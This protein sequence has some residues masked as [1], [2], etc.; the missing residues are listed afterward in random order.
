M[1]AI[2]LMPL[3][4]FLATRVPGA[5]ASISWVAVY[6]IPLLLVGSLAQL[7]I[8]DTL[9]IQ[10]LSIATVY[11]VYEVGYLQND[12]LT[13]RGE[14]SPTLRLSPDEMDNV[15]RRFTVIALVRAVIVILLLALLYQMDPPGMQGLLVSLAIL[16]PT[17]VIYNL[18]RGAIN[19]PLHFLLVSLRFC[20]PVLVLIPYPDATLLLY[21]ILLFPLIN[22]LER[23]AE[24]RYGLRWA[25][26]NPLA[27]QSSGRWQYYLGLGALWSVT[28][29][30]LDVNVMTLVPIAYLFAYRL[31]S[32][33]ALSR[34]VRSGRGGEADQ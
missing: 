32:P 26:A 2:Y 14:A 34:L 9:A 11:A 8:I 7:P 18:T 4:Y 16:I 5:I 12:A 19:V 21:L 29:V 24:P 23:A 6:V 15:R 25:Q 3:G 1:K 13:T 30:G 20:A 22:T 31:L 17:F 28:C 10:L 27:N 33:T